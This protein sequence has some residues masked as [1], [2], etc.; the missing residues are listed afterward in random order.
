[1]FSTRCP[2]ATERCRAE[3]PV[4]RLIDTR[5]VACHEAERLTLPV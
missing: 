3:R 1:V 5:Q 2:H 4:L